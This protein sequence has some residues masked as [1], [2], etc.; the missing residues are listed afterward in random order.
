MVGKGATVT[1]SSNRVGIWATTA[2]VTP[3]HTV[4]MWGGPDRGDAPYEPLVNI[5]KYG[6][7]ACYDD[8]VNA[9][10]SRTGAPL[11]EYYMIRQILENAVCRHSDRLQ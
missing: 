4:E 6:T 10:E 3:L 8:A 7:D 2:M 5:A 1:S 11:E 9:I